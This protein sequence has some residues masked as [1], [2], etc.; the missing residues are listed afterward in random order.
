MPAGG[1]VLVVGGTGLLGRALVHAVG[2]TAVA[3]WHRTR[4]A[5]DATWVTLDLAEPGQ[6]ERAIAEHAPAL[7]I[8]A[9]YARGG[10]DLVPVTERGAAH[11]ARAAADIHASLV[12]LSTDVV[13]AGDRTAAYVETDRPAPVH[14]YGAAKARAE[15]AVIATHPAPLVVRTSLLYGAPDGVQERLVLGAAGAGTTFFTDEVRAPVHVD[16]LATAIL[17]L[18]DEGAS[19]IVHL[20]GSDAVDRLT[21]ARLLAPTLGVDPDTLT[22]GP[23]DPAMVRPRHVVLA[24]DRV[25]PLPGCRHRLT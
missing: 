8:N 22:G 24:S 25:D 23:S 15:T 2:P 19:G 3:T 10:E 20:A 11:L 13:F 12:H 9:A 16:D 1:P 18:A 6:I 5:A 21:F 17:G 7:V 14:E 4:P